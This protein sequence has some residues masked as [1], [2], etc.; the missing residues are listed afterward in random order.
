METAGF[1]EPSPRDNTN[2]EYFTIEPLNFHP[3]EPVKQN[4]LVTYSAVDYEGLST[5]CKVPIEIEGT[6]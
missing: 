4:M 6:V 2:I 1:F 5:T 3:D